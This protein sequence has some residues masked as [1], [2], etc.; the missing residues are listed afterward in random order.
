MMTFLQTHIS[1]IIRIIFYIIIVSLG[2]NLISKLTKHLTHALKLKDTNSLLLRFM[3][4]LDNIIKVVFLFFIVIIFLKRYGIEA[5]SL[6]A[7]I[8]IGGL[9]IGFAAKE[10]IANLFGSVAL[11]LDNAYKVGDY[12]YISQ[13]IMG[14]NVEGTVVDINLRSTK[15]RTMDNSLIIIP[16]NVTANQVVSNISRRNKRLIRE[17]ITLTYKAN[18]ET[19]LEAINIIYDI[20]KSNND[21][22]KEDMNVVLESLSDYS[23]NLLVLAY[24]NKTL[25]GNYIK[26]KSE[27]LLN[28]YD[29]FNEN[30]I[31]FAY[32]TQ[33]IEIENKG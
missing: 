11:I 9:A 33:T 24:S 30:N 27:L 10:T 16:N 17:T 28:I 22:D 25:Y 20:L 1:E 5:T 32:P 13:D 26:V 31:E 8:G 23:V 12:I 3:P 19:I 21:L 29:K 15:L 14:K 2:L 6:L 7:G 18:R 4:L